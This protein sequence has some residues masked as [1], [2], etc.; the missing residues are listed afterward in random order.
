MLDNDDTLSAQ[1][2]KI[3]RKKLIFVEKLQSVTLK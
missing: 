2:Y 1:C 3:K